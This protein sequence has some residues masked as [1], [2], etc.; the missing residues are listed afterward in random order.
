MAGAP[1]VVLRFKADVTDLDLCV[2]LLDVYPDGRRML[3]DDGC[4]RAAFIDGF[5]QQDEQLLT[6]GSWYTLD[7]ELPVFLSICLRGIVWEY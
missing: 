5:T 6:P 1:R 4:H 7:W 2:R 3:I